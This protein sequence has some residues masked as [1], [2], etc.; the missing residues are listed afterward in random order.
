MA[1]KTLH[2]EVAADLDRKRRL[3]LEARAASALNDPHIVVL[4]DVG[5]ADGIDFLV[6]EYVE[7]QTLDKLIPSVGME[8]QQALAYAAEIA[9]GLATAHEPGI[10]HRDLKPGN[11]MITG[12]GAV[13][14]LDFGLAKL[15]EAPQASAPGSGKPS[16]RRRADPRHG[17][18]HVART[19]ARAAGGCALG[20]VLVRCGAV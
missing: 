14:V 9:A 1:L 15:T 12:K 20:H 13:K 7:G 8:T 4:Y 6:M 3:L 19:S 11:I 5:S 2:P 16:I 10:I 17:R 18:L